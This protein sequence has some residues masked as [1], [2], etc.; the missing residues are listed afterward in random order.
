MKHIIENSLKTSMSYQEYI[1]LVDNL[2]LTNSTTGP[3]KTET[4]VNYTALN[5]RRMSRW[6]KKLSLTESQKETVKAFN[7]QIIWLVLTESWCGDAAHVMP[8]INKVAELNDNINLRVVLRD[9]NL[10]LMDLFLTNGGRSIPKLIMLDAKSH[11][12]IGTFGPRPSAATQM[13]NDYKET[14]GVLT[15]E[16]KEDLQLW[17]NKDKGQTIVKDLINLLPVNVSL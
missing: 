14:H 6:N 15:A 4:L 9:E 17:Y 3:E 8:V 10:E 12:V 11:D 5:Q 7:N 16:F 2:T 1:N 13:V